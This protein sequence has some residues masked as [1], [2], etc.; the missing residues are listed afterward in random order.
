MPHIHLATALAVLALGAWGCQSS[1]AERPTP[2]AAD[3]ARTSGQQELEA[4]GQP[5]VGAELYAYSHSI[6]SLG[7]APGQFKEPVGVATNAQGELYVSDAGNKRMQKLDAK[8]NSLA[9]WA[10]G[11]GRPMHLSWSK[12]G[13]LLTAVFLE[14]QIKL[15]EDAEL[16][17]SFGG[18]WLDAPGGAVEA[19]DGRFYV[20][21][22]YH[23]Q[24]H[25]VS[26]G[27][28]RLE[29]IGEKGEED[30]QFTYPT[31]VALDSEGN[32]WI[33]DA[34]AHRLQ[35]FSPDGEHLVTIGGWGE[36]PGKFRV[37]TGIDIGPDGRIYVAD[38]TNNRVQVLDPD[39]TPVAVFGSAGP[40]GESMGGESMKTPTD[41]V[42]TNGRVYVVDHG[43]H[44]IDVWTIN[45]RK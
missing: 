4:D 24:F 33:A 31:D 14:D 9:V 28:Q 23:H 21:D 6:G 39:G 36:E 30:A 16:A 45:P 5:E 41:V 20:A 1:K 35:K 25:I 12:D 13:Q 8:G 37:A 17:S 2:S 27:G 18:E 44:Q 3:E 15:F 29:T 26:P 42:A 22:F 43:H 10:E 38:F 32:V 11:I 19:D 40:E 7:D 34:Y